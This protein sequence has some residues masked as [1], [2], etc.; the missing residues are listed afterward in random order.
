MAFN[1]TGSNVTSLN[2]SNIASGTVATARLGSGTPSSSNFLRGD[3]SWQTPTSGGVTSFNG[4]TGALEGWQDITSGTFGSGT[5]TLSIGSLPADYKAF[6]FLITTSTS[7]TN[8]NFEP[9]VRLSTDGGSSYISSNIYSG[10]AINH[11]LQYGGNVAITNQQ[12][13]SNWYVSGGFNFYGADTISNDPLI[14][15]YTLTQS[16]NGQNVKLHG[17]IGAFVTNGTQPSFINMFYGFMSNTS[18]INGFQF[19]RVGSN[20]SLNAGTFYVYGAK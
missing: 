17:T 10:I 7:S 12:N 3:G 16:A 13:Q 2:A 14:I 15:D 8:G 6:R 4:N 5:T 20:K 11:G 9:G 19:L 18:Y 1:G